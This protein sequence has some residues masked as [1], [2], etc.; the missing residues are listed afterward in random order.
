MKK[1]KEY[2]QERSKVNVGILEPM[3]SNRRHT[4]KG[5]G[6]SGGSRSETGRVEGQ[7]EG[8]EPSGRVEQR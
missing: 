4:M 1:I 5:G 2:K 6:V 7:R 3:R 8:E